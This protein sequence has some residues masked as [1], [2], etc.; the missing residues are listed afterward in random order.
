MKI[1]AGHTNFVFC[2]NFNPRSNL[3]VSGGFD[4]TVR[5]WDVAEGM[6]YYYYVCIVS[7]L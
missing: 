4:E 3:L 2:V 5:V 6:L 7:Y 1:L